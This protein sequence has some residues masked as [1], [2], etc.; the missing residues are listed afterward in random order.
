MQAMTGDPQPKLWCTSMLNVFKI[1]A[2]PYLRYLV[3]VYAAEL[4]NCIYFLKI[5][6][7]IYTDDEDEVG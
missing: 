3:G 1:N 2:H 6:R 5:L 7:L 4:L